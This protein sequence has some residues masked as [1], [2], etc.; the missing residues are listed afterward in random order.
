MPLTSAFWAE[1]WNG[2]TWRAVATARVPGGIYPTGLSGVSCTGAAACLA[3]GEYR[4][5]S[6]SSLGDAG[7]ALAQR[8]N[9]TTWQLS[10]PRLA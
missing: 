2:R 10:Q 9:G 6:G 8:W 4:A 5:G 7:L 3:G 1:I